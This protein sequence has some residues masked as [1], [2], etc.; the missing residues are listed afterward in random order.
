MSAILLSAIGNF[1]DPILVGSSDWYHF[2]FCLVWW[3]VLE[4]KKKKKKRGLNETTLKHESPTIVSAKIVKGR[5][6]CCNSIQK[7][8]PDSISYLDCIFMTDQFVIEKGPANETFQDQFSIDI[9]ITI[10][11]KAQDDN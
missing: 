6:F 4:K 5:Q 1:D 11:S 3:W 8:S 2:F 7:M 9:N 10:S